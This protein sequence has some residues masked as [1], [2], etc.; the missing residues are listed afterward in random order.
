MCCMIVVKAFVSISPSN[1][2]HSP[3]F[4]LLTHKKLRCIFS[5]NYLVSLQKKRH[6]YLVNFLKFDLR[7]AKS[8]VLLLHK[9]VV[10]HNCKQLTLL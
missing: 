4:S 8:Y 10:G 6:N 9:I 7:A 5:H 3:L 2:D 1:V